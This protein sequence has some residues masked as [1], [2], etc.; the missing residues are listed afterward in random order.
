[1]SA[2]NTSSQENIPSSH[3]IGCRFKLALTATGQVLEQYKNWD[4]PNI[5][6]EG[7]A[8]DYPN[9]NHERMPGFNV[10]RAGRRQ[11]YNGISQNGRH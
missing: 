7:M 6:H 3:E 4:Y 5:S 2:M 9:I 8:K 11:T 10:L 1:M